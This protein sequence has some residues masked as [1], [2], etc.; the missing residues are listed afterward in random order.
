VGGD[1]SDRLHSQL[2]F[3]TL[4]VDPLAAVQALDVMRQD[5]PLLNRIRR[6]VIG[7]QRNG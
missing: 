7:G 5:L 4:G 1:L 3:E 6:T 2:M